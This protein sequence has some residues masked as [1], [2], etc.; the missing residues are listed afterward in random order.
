[1]VQV[2]GQDVAER[3]HS[4]NAMPRAKPADATDR[5]VSLPP[6]EVLPR[7]LLRA[8][9]A[10]IVR[11]DPSGARALLAEAQRQLED[12]DAEGEANPHGGSR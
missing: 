4:A 11:G 5:V 12:D 10:A 9:D 1:V 3:E 8:V 6:R 2:V 7:D